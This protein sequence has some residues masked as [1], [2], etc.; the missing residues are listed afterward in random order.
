MKEKL[1]SIVIPFFNAKNEDIK[2]CLDSI[3]SQE[4]RQDEFEVIVVND[5][6]TDKN[7]VEYLNSYKFLNS[8]PPQFVDYQS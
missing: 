2:R 8:A 5:C 4:L 1:L 3:Y 7:T 6:S